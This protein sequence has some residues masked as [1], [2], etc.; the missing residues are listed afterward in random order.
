MTRSA[1]YTTLT[2][3]THGALLL[4]VL[5]GCWRLCPASES[6]ETSRLDERAATD[7]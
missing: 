5:S 6:A 7:P 3:A 1:S 4:E 2:D